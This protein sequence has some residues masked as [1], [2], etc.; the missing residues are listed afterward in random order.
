LDHFPADES[1]LS[2]RDLLAVAVRVRQASPVDS[3]L[4]ASLVQDVPCRETRRTRC[5]AGE[6]Q[7]KHTLKFIHRIIIFL[8]CFVD[9]TLQGSSTG[10]N[11][12]VLH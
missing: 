1:F 5:P 2:L 4:P 10:S 11:R 3:V 7:Q 9:A 8:L 6:D 12:T